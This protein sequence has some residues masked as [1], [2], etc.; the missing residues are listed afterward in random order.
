VSYQDL[1]LS[2]PADAAALLR[3]I[4]WAAREVC[5]ELDGP[6]P[7]SQAVRGQ[8]CYAEAVAR[9]VSSLHAQALTAQYLSA[10]GPAAH[11]EAP[12]G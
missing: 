11:A 4:E 9:A 8:Q 12:R 2:R 1:S 5:G 6:R 7:L 3:R 10:F